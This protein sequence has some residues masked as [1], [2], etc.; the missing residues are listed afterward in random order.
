MDTYLGYN[1]ILMYLLNEEKIAFITLTTNYCYKVMLFGLKNTWAIYQRLMNKIFAEHIKTL[2]EVYIDD[3]LVKT[4]EEEELLPNLE[5]VF[6]CLCNHMM[7]LIKSSKVC[8]RRWSRK[9]FG[10]YAYTSRD[11][12]ES[13]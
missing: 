7:K 4:M 5:I 13:W 12:D 2:M 3:M 6:D 11:W 1:Q 9:I 10:F 8:L